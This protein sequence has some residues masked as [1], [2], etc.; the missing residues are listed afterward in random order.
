MHCLGSEQQRLNSKPLCGPF[1]SLL[2]CLLWDVCVFLFVS[3]SI[4]HNLAFPISLLGFTLLQITTFFIFPPRQQCTSALSP[5][6]SCSSLSL[7][8]NLSCHMRMFMNLPG[9]SVIFCPEVHALTFSTF[10]I[11]LW[12]CAH[13]HLFIWIIIILLK[14]LFNTFSYILMGQGYF[15]IYRKQTDSKQFKIDL[16]KVFVNFCQL[17]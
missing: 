12:T 4:H 14:I 8:S 17:T 6:P 7:I 2:A 10:S 13:L 5:T 11:F 15:L 16:K 9:V 1:Y 3:G